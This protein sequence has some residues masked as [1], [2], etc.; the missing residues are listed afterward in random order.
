MG[1]LPDRECLCPPQPP[2]CHCH[3]HIEDHPQTECCARNPVRRPNTFWLQTSQQDFRPD[4]IVRLKDARTWIADCKG[5]T[6]NE[7]Q[8]DNEKQIIGSTWAA[9]SGGTRLSLFQPP[10]TTHPS[11]NFGENL[12]LTGRRP[13]VG[14]TLARLVQELVWF[15]VKLGLPGVLLLAGG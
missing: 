15:G 5:K 13:C 1:T 3:A 14:G 6:W 8:S 7:L 9:A 10:R 4:F 12:S 2:P 11:P